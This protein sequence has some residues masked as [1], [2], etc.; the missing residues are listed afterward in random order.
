SMKPLPATLTVYSPA[1][2]GKPGSAVKSGYDIAWG[3]TIRSDDQQQSKYPVSTLDTTS[4]ATLFSSTDASNKQISGDNII[5]GTAFGFVQGQEPY[6]NQFPFRAGGNQVLKINFQLNDNA[7]TTTRI[8]SLDGTMIRAL[9]NSTLSIANCTSDCNYCNSKEGC[10]W[11]GTSY[12]GGNHFVANGMYI[13]N[14]HAI[15]TGNVF[16]NSSIDYTKGI[17]VM[18]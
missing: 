2:P 12:E 8:Y 1:G 16:P 11:D 4:A 5:V 15:C 3:I 18:K 6:P 14:I 7:N 9:E 13:F 10:I 17:V